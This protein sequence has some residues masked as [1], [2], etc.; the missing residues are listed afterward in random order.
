VFSLK[1]AVDFFAR[2]EF[3]LRAPL[4]SYHPGGAFTLRG[5]HESV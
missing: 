3:R 5:G 2:R 1:P 4:A